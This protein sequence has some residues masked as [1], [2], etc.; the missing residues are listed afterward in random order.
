MLQR[1][2]L[3][4]LGFAVV[5]FEAAELYALPATLD[6][7]LPT[8][9]QGI[10]TVTSQSIRASLY[11]PGSAQSESFQT[12]CY[13]ARQACEW[14]RK[15]P[16]IPVKAGVLRFA[17]PYHSWLVSMSSTNDFALESH[18]Q[19]KELSSYKRRTKLGLVALLGVTVALWVALS[20]RS[21]VKRLA[22]ET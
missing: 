5:M 20:R 22:A 12:S 3:A 4:L 7:A 11:I 10:P 1:L 9:V 17:W 18:I 19:E 6:S 15:N 16:G 13:L 2:L 8:I 14:V 21:S